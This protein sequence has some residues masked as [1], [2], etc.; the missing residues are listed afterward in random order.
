VLCNLSSLLADLATPQYKDR[1]AGGGFHSSET[2]ASSQASADLKAQIPA[3]AH[4]G[5]KVPLGP[6]Q[7]YI[8]TQADVDQQGKDGRKAVREANKLAKAECAHCAHK[9][10]PGVRTHSTTRAVACKMHG[11]TCDAVTKAHSRDAKKATATTQP[12]DA[13]SS[14]AARSADA[15]RTSIM[16]AFANLF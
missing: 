13:A 16:S 1:K 12:A 9:G 6:N 11:F 15:A 5:L 4:A 3:G 10:F 14:A 2:S 8:V 7:F